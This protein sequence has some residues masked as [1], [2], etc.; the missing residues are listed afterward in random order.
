MTLVIKRQGISN[1]INEKQNFKYYTLKRKYYVKVES[2]GPAKDFIPIRLGTMEKSVQTKR[3][4][5]M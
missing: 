3:R 1:R 2:K 5:K 4:Q